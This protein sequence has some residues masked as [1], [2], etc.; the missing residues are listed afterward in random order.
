MKLKVFINIIFTQL[1]RCKAARVRGSYSD[2]NDI[3][4]GCKFP[5]MKTCQ[6]VHMVSFVVL[7]FLRQFQKMKLCLKYRRKSNV[8]AG[9]TI[10]RVHTSPSESN[11]SWFTQ[12]NSALLENVGLG[13]FPVKPPLSR[14]FFPMTVAISF[15]LEALIAT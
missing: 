4:H 10:T 9:P 13:L 6:S 2:I 5:V 15:W 12:L 14:C 7:F 3:I 1:S 11:P 8:S